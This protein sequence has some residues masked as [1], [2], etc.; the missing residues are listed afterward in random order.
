M[1]R[2]TVLVLVAAIA[3]STGVAACQGLK[4]AFT[5]HGNMAAKAGS[6]QLTVEQLSKLLTGVQVPLTPDIA[7][8]ITNIWVDYQLLGEA[9]ANNDTLNQPKAVDDA[10]WAFLA[11]QRVGKFHDQLVKTYKGID[12]AATPAE[13]AKGEYLAAQHILFIV[14]PTATPAQKDSVRREAQR[15]RGMLNAENFAEMAKKY[16]QDPGSAARGGDLGVFKN[17]PPMVQPFLTAVVALQPGQISGLV[18]TQ[19]GYHIIRR[20]PL[21]EVRADFAREA[22]GPAIAR[23]DSIWMNGLET[24]A[25]IKFKDNAAQLVKTAVLDLDAH[26]KDGAVLAT[27][28][29]GDFTVGRLVKWLESAPQKEQLAEQVRQMQDTMVVGLLKQVLR[30]ELVLAA[31]DSAKVVLDSAELATIHQRYS[32]AVVN[33]W[34]QL[35]VTP[36]LLADS[37]KTSSG[38]EAVAAR[39]VNDF[40]DKLMKQ[41]A[42][43]VAVAPPVSK[44]AR[45][46]YGAT[47]SVAG[48]QRAVDE[49][50]KAKAAAD[51]ARLKSR[52]PT[53]VPIGAPPAAPKP[54]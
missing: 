20:R 42:Q 33:V 28:K 45:S 50:N 47:L 44:V 15:V 32:M 49:T 41:Q 27:W 29:G 14:Q 54:R 13:Y 17:G 10:L 16:S 11:Q 22:A 43:Y 26:A 46:K 3:L 23:A 6:Q 21:A 37:A 30:N 36:K 4:E 34:T 52:P 51:S 24:A 53:E 31:A 38:R 7:K 25:N 8:A 12:S 9:A 39:Q 19:F 2:R 5:A 1:K 18:Q 48:M 35:N 40:I